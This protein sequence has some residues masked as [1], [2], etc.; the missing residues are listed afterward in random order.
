MSPQETIV[1]RLYQV[2]TIKRVA[3]RFLSKHRK[4]LIVHATGTGKTRVAIALSEL[5]IRAGW[6]KRVL[7]LCDRRE[8]RRQAKNAFTDFLPSEPIRIVNSRISGAPNERVFVAHLSGY[9]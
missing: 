7:Y 3:E 9:A 2:E 4:A 8:L 6:A 5:L 1:D